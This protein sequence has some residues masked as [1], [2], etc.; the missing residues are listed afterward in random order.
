[1]NSE[2]LTQMTEKMNSLKNNVSN[3]VKSNNYLVNLMVIFF[4]MFLV[5]L[6]FIYIQT[7]LGKKQ[8]NCDKIHSYYKE[9]NSLSSINLN[10]DEYKYLLNEYYILSAYNCCCSGNNKNDYVDL[11]ALENCIK[12]GARF[13]DFQIYNKNNKPVVASSSKNSFKY[14]ETY[15]YLEISDVFQT[16]NNKAFVS[17]SCP[18]PNDPLL[19]YFRMYTDDQNIY[20]TLGE[21]INSYLSERLLSSVTYSDESHG[22]NI[23]NKKL[24]NFMKKIIIIVDKTDESLFNNSKLK[25]YTN[26]TSG[27]KSPFIQ[28]MNYFSI[29]TNQDNSSL[30]TYNKLNSTIVIPDLSTS[31]LNYDPSIPL[32]T[33]CQFIS[34]NIQN[35]DTYLQFLMD[36]FNNKNSAFILKPDNLRPSRQVIPSQNKIPDD[37]NCIPKDRTITVGT[38]EIKVTV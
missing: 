15:N 3:I 17:G 31:N 30:I 11:C 9:S 19:L 23:F 25:H 4:I 2:S 37:Q 13:L 27:P 32:S 29:S 6:L 5:F 18:N 16:I 38:E 12:Q 26:I 10:N 8:T 22:N 33:G 28:K 14:K 35:K 24:Y 20:D 34:M 7:E 36:K 21:N 1:M